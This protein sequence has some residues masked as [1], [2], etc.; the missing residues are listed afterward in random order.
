MIDVRDVDKYDVVLAVHSSN[1]RSAF[2]VFE[3]GTLKRKGDLP[4]E[5]AAWV[6]LEAM[7]S[8]YV[9]FR[10]WERAGLDP[11]KEVQNE[12]LNKPN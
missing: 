4:T 9:K 8:Q 3:E 7:A 10:E 1:G 5:E 6:F 2:I 11:E 12:C